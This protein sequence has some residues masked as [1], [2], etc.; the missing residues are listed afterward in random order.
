MFSRFATK[1]DLLALSVQCLGKIKVLLR[2][3][4]IYEAG[5]RNKH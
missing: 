1:Y 3:A 2:G 5:F 4:F